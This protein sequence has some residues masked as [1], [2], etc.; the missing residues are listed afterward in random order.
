MQIRCYRCGTSFELGRA[1]MEQ[2]VEEA[3]KEG[4]KAYVVECVRCRQAIKVPIA[5][6]RRGLP[7]KA[8]H[9]P[10]APAEPEAPPPAEPEHKTPKKRATAQDA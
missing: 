4:H 10:D 1:A 9:A 2:A 8:P 7:P 6:I 3:E 5:Q